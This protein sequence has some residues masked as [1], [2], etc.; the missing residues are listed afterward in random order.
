MASEIKPKFY[1]SSRDIWIVNNG[2]LKP[3]FYADSKN[4]WK[5]TGDTI[6]PK[7]GANSSNRWRYSYS[8]LSGG[9]EE[10]TFNGKEFCP[11]RGGSRDIWI[12]ERGE[13]KPKFYGSSKDIYVYST[14]INPLI[15]AFVHHVILGIREPK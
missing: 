7:F 13:M 14:D 5:I 15:V 4:T 6:E 12:I 10:F 2:E 1:G 9:G 11:K 3:K 8:G